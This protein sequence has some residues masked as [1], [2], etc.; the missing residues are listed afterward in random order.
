M[1]ITKKYLVY[2]LGLVPLGFFLNWRVNTKNYIKKV[3]FQIT[4]PIMS[5]IKDELGMDIPLRDTVTIYYDSSYIVY[6]KAY[7][8]TDVNI[9]GNIIEDDTTGG[10]TGTFKK[11]NSEINSNVSSAFFG[12][13]KGEN[14]GILYYPFDH[15]VSK[16]RVD[17]MKVQWG[18][19]TFKT[20]LALENARLVNRKATLN[21]ITEKYITINKKDE[22]YPDSI[23]VYYSSAIKGDFFSFNKE[24]EEKNHM[25]IS[26]I[27][28]FFKKSYSEIYATTLPDRELSVRMLDSKI[29][30]YDKISKIFEKFRKND[31]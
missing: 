9:F 17:T 6:E 10:L 24:L 4:F 28:M 16:Q 18:G 5:P 30:D 25:K 22:T 13:L 1:M 19:E 20:F 29:T 7:F 15:Q 31:F 27:V 14:Y 26:D 11:T 21:R 23:F 12:Y 3:S 8:H 2:I